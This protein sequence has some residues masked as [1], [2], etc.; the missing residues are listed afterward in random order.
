MRGVLSRSLFDE[1]VR[2]T[3]E[4]VARLEREDLEALGVYAPQF[5]GKASVENRGTFGR[6]KSTACRRVFS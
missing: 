1:L 4:E 3:D 6:N 2:E 5:A